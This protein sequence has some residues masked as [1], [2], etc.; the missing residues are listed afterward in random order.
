M[1]KEVFQFIMFLRENEPQQLKRLAR[2]I[3]HLD[4]KSAMHVVCELMKKH[5]QVPY[6][7]CIKYGEYVYET[8]LHSL[9]QKHSKYLKFDIQFFLQSIP[10]HD[11]TTLRNHIESCDEKR[12]T[13]AVQLLCKHLSKYFCHHIFAPSCQHFCERY[14]TFV[15]Y[16]LKEAVDSIKKNNN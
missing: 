10:T 6:N 15:F 8:L 13:L 12:Y 7:E 1:K 14:G 5:K 4:K 3:Q 2:S 11:Y 16:V 9:L